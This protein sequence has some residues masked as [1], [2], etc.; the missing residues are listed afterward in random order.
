[1]PRLA[2]PLCDKLSALDAPLIA[3]DIGLWNWLSL[4]Y[5]DQLCPVVSD[6]TRNLLA[7]E[8][9]VMSPDRVYRQVFRH[10][11]RGPWYAV[12]EHGENAKVLLIHTERSSVVLA[13][14]GRIFE[15][16]ASRQGIFGNRTV[17]AAAQRLYFD[18]RNNWPRFGASG[19]APGSVRRYAIVVQQ[20]EL[21]YDTRACSVDQFL[22]LLPREFNEWK[23]R[24]QLALTQVA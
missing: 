19:H 10:L 24:A 18:E 13:T 20:L 1:M 3:R 23:A 4:Y 7:T 8:V 6:R 9:Y 12:R 2:C 5:F 17:I 16:L 15:D 22:G 14:R 11:V 21:T